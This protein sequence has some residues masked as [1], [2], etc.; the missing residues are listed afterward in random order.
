MLPGMALSLFSKWDEPV[1]YQLTKPLSLPGGEVWPAGRVVEVD[2]LH[3][4]YEVSLPGGHFYFVDA[5]YIEPAKPPRTALERL[6]G[7]DV[8][9]GG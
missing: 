1:R 2:R 6:V 9:W 8:P 5:D 4:G 7:P 3:W